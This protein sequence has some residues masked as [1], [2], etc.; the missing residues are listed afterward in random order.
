MKILKKIIIFTL[1]LV[2][3]MCFSNL[4]CRPSRAS[5]AAASAEDSNLNMQQLAKDFEFITRFYTD[6]E[7]LLDYFLGLSSSVAFSSDVKQC[8]YYSKIYIQSNPYAEYEYNTCYTFF[9]NQSVAI[10]VDAGVDMI[11]FGGFAVSDMAL[12][13]TMYN[14]QGN[15]CYSISTIFNF[16]ECGK[17]WYFA[18]IGQSETARTVI[19]TSED[20]I[21]PLII[22]EMYSFKSSSLSITE[23]ATRQQN[24]EV[25]YTFV[26]TLAKTKSN[27]GIVTSMLPYS[28]CSSLNFCSAVYPTYGSNMGFYNGIYDAFFGKVRKQDFE[29]NDRF[30]PADI[31]D[32]DIKKQINTAHKAAYADFYDYI[33]S[34]KTS[35][36]VVHYNKDNLPFMD[37][38][39]GAMIDCDTFIKEYL[40]DNTGRIYNYIDETNYQTLVNSRE[41]Y[42]YFTES[43][44]A[45]INEKIA[46]ANGAGSRY[47]CYENMYNDAAD[48]AMARKFLDDYYGDKTYLDKFVITDVE[49][50]KR[51]YNNLPLSAQE[52]VNKI[53]TERNNGLEKTVDETIADYIKSTDK[54]TG[55]KVNGDGSGNEGVNL[56]DFHIDFSKWSL[57]D[58]GKKI[59][60]F[61]KNPGKFFEEVGKAI[62]KAPLVQSFHLILKIIFAVFVGFLLFKGV[63]AIVDLVRAR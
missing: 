48:I 18:Y 27:N 36:T 51:A 31:T 52:E 42:Y 2:T 22:E 24:G 35:D 37:N 26:P 10:T 44:K 8:G 62:A 23:I 53:L 21:S 40:T 47:N 28:P 50:V 49:E 59:E 56:D 25:F 63:K 45:Y 15:A 38:Y 20:F 3:A 33:D 61:F 12:N 58:L 34:N 60:A 5:A 17:N 4:L 41:S 11:A 16:G 6:G 57:D 9:E 1:A 13:E 39:S 29:G 55:N 19:I 46:S 7:P 54:N 30:Y 14:E 43:Q 32:K